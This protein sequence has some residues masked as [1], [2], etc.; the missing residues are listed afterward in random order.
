MAQEKAEKLT[1]T[2]EIF[3]GRPNP[4]FDIKEANQIT[5]LREAL[6]NLPESAVTAQEASQFNRLGYRGIIIMNTGGIKGIPRY[7]QL[8]KGKVKTI[9]GTGRGNTRFFDDAKGMERYYLGLAKK[10]GLIPRD[11]LEERI[12][13]DPDT[14]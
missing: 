1:V 8:L 2:V 12:V 9:S 3:S 4:T 5:E 10:K 11:L 14:M 13:P 7:V 6:A